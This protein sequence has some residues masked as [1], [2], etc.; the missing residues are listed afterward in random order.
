MKRYEVHY[1]TGWESTLLSTFTDVAEAIAFANSE[2]KGEERAENLFENDE[3][4]TFRME[5]IAIDE[6]DVDSDGEPL[7]ETVYETNYYWERL[8]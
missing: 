1:N 2:V 7:F 4:T 5:V 8:P 3:A 6:E